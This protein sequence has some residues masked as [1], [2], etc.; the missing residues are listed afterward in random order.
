MGNTSIEQKNI[1]EMYLVHLLKSVV[2]FFLVLNF[3]SPYQDVKNHD[4][5]LLINILLNKFKNINMAC[6]T[7]IF[8]FIKNTYDN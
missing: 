1:I 4:S 7:K 6:K 3:I 2:K 5:E 8:S